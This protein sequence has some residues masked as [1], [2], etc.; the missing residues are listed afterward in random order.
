[1]KKRLVLV[2]LVSFILHAAENKR[3]DNDAMYSQALRLALKGQFFESRDLLNQVL[4]KNPFHI[5]SRR[6]LDLLNDMELGRV[7][8]EAVRLICCGIEA[9]LGYE[10]KKALEWYQQALEMAPGYYFLQHNLATSLMET[11]Q[12]EKSVAEYK[13]AL[14]LKEDYPYTHN[15]LGLALDR[16]GRYKEAV[17]SYKR[18]IALF[19]Q[20]HK[21]YNNLGATY[22]SMEMEKEGQAMMKKAL[23]INADYTLAF[24]NLD[25]DFEND[26]EESA[27]DA[28]ARVLRPPSSTQTLLE[29][30]ATGPALERKK[31]QAE[32]SQS[33]DPAA[34][35]ILI[36][37]LDSSSSLLRA[38]AA[39][40]L[41]ETQCREALPAMTLLA[42]DPE[43]TVRQAAIEALGELN[44]PTT[45][46]TVLAA[47]RDPDYHVRIKAIYAAARANNLEA[48]EPLL[49]MLDDPMEMVRAACLRNLS[50]M[51]AIIPRETIMTLLRHERGLEREVA[52]RIVDEG[53]IRMENAEE[54]TAYCAAAQQWR[55]LEQMDLAGVD[56]LRTALDFQDLESRIQA[57]KTLSRMKNA[58]ALNHLF[59]ALKDE[60]PQVQEAACKGLRRA[61]GLDLS[62]VVQ[63]RAYFL[64]KTGAK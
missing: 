10:Q 3:L 54:R 11:G 15:N 23:E 22:F 43:W 17:A 25:P 46:L 48:L 14:T 47:L 60:E 20:Y 49:R 12:A 52:V 34:V 19:P 5:A 37:M 33:N 16:L 61:T 38:A 57:V 7:P 28:L 51:A 58:N 29:T 56:A 2:V 35:P 63:W 62:T 6:G 39:Q 31:A 9:D 45:F 18:A 53:R 55:Q 13:K 1:M 30:L 27:V 24:Q 32:L 41:G 40:I 44:D 50:S 26:D 64:E 36:K 8:A 21:A 4:A 42:N 59:Y